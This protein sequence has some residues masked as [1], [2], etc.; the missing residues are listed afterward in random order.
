VAQTRKRRRR[1]HRGT[2]GGAI[3]KR[4]RG[5]A[6]SREQAKAQAR[7]RQELRREAPPTWQT[8]FNR[9]AI[10][11]LVFFALMALLFGRSIGEALI[12][13][14]VMLVIYVPLGYYM[15]RFFYLRRRAAAL[16]ARRQQ[17]GRD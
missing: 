12:L 5:R 8:A 3:D 2:Q 7:R 13:S 15:D 1:K 10:G 9:G 4:G 16:R 17:T 14:V 11:A 6:R